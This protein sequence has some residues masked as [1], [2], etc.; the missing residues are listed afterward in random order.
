MLKFAAALRI[1][2]DDIT[3]FQ[4]GLTNYPGLDVLH[5]GTQGD[6]IQEAIRKNL[7]QSLG[8]LTD[9]LS[10]HTTEILDTHLPVGRG[11]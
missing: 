6:I 8:S 3:L 11:E 2:A 4:Q 5:A 9:V 1:L 7:T 10:N